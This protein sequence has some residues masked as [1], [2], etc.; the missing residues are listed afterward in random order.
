[1]D[2][3]TPKALKAQMLE[4]INSYINEVRNT[5]EISSV[6]LFGSYTKG[7]QNK[8]S[9]ID[10]AIVCTE[11]K[12]DRHAFLVNL[13]RK[14]RYYDILIEPHPMTIEE[15]MDPHYLLGKEVLKYGIKLL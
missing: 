10:L 15:L 3:K 11:A 13:L 5:Y 4:Q 6:Y 2:K 14:S 1:M 9:D 7:T 8:Y 12:K